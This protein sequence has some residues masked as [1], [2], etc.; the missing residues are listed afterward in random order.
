MYYYVQLGDIAS[1][2]VYQRY[3]LVPDRR[4][5]DEEPHDMRSAEAAVTT[6]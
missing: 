2:N 3:P 4:H 1:S 5:Y 6:P